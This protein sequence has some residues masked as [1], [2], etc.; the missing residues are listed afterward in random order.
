LL[1]SARDF[2]ATFSFIAEFASNVLYNNFLL[3]EG[4]THNIDTRK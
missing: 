1:Q 3:H 4:N 2:I